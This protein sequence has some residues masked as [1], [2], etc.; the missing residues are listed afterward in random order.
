MFTAPQR[1]PQ[2][3]PVCEIQPF[4]VQRIVRSSIV[5]A[6]RRSQSSRYLPA[7]RTLN[8]VDRTIRATAVRKTSTAR[9]SREGNGPRR[10][11]RAVA[12]G[13]MP[14]TRRQAGGAVR[15]V[16][17]PLG[18]GTVVRYA[19]SGERET[20]EAGADSLHTESF[21]SPLAPGLGI[22]HL[23]RGVVS[24]LARASAAE[25][26]GRIGAPLGVATLTAPSRARD[27]RC[28]A[29]SATASRA[30]RGKP[31]KNRRRPL[32]SHH[33][34]AAGPDVPGGA[35]RFWL[36]I[37]EDGWSS[38]VTHAAGA[39]GHHVAVRR[40][41]FGRCVDA[42]WAWDIIWAAQT[43]SAPLRA[44]A[45]WRGGRRSRSRRGA[46]WSLARRSE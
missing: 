45:R 31:R 37:T 36:I 20:L 4:R 16:P 38:R 27:C 46:M 40:H 33:S 5:T 25:L 28:Q 3:A 1:T 14:S 35:S 15:G 10:R 22:G 12:Y 29:D 34:R 2:N 19:G 9:R 11:R 30:S 13:R 21:R 8:T 18:T 39:V 23:G 26:V 44:A 42:K 43:C 17:L 32:P 41:G 6:A 24:S 7:D